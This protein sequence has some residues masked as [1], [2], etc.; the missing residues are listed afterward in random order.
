MVLEV[1]D[2][3]SSTE[4]AS[5]ISRMLLLTV[6][7]D[8]HSH[9]MQ[10]IRLAEVHD[11]EFHLHVLGR[12]R[13]LKEEPLGVAIGVNIILQQEVIL[14]IVLLVG[15]AEVPTLETR[16]EEECPVIVILE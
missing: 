7:H 3:V 14:F 4:P 13:D 9:I 5:F 11:I 6:N 16:F 10:G 15:D 1:D 2:V 8:L 12:I